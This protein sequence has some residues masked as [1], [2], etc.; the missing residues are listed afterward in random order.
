MNQ[1]IRKLLLLSFL[2]YSVATAQGTL[3]VVDMEVGSYHKF[4]NFEFHS[5]QQYKK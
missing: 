1:K 3:P 2:F 4:I 5:Q